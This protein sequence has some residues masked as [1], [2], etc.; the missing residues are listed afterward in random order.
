[1]RN[2]FLVALILQIIGGA[3]MDLGNRRFKWYTFTDRA[4]YVLTFVLIV[5]NFVASYCIAYGIVRA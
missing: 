2:H 1:M 3:I 5:I 4:S